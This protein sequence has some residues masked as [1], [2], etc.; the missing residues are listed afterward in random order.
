MYE[1]VWVCVWVRVYIYECVGTCVRHDVLYGVLVRVSEGDGDAGALGL[2]DVV[3]LQQRTHAERIALQLDAHAAIRATRVA[4]APWALLHFAYQSINIF[5][6]TWYHNLFFTTFLIATHKRITRAQTKAR[7]ACSTVTS[8]WYYPLKKARRH[9]FDL[10]CYLRPRFLNTPGT[11]GYETFYITGK[12]N[13]CNNELG[14]CCLMHAC[15][16]KGRHDIL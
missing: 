16:R 7:E 15:A 1:C 10:P 14:D 11:S 8:T 6:L 3:R 4:C 5:L 2:Q 13:T 9:P 12:L